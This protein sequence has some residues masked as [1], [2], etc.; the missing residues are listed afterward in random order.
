MLSFLSRL[1]LVGRAFQAVPA[2]IPAQATIRVQAPIQGSIPGRR[3]Q[4]LLPKP[5]GLPP[6]LAFTLEGR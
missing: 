2:P 4:V 5:L 1:P 6:V 3:P